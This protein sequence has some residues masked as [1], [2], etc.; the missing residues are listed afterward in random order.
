[1]AN[2]NPRIDSEL[3]HEIQQTAQREMELQRSRDSGLSL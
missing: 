1:M 2:I 3:G